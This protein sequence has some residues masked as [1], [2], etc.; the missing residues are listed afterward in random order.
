MIKYNQ[1]K[2]IMGALRISARFRPENKI[3]KD[4]AVSKDFTGVRGGKM[5][6]CAKCK[7][8]Y[9]PKQINIDH[10]KP[11]IPLNKKTE[12]MSWDEIIKRL[13]CPIFNLQVLCV[14]CHHEKSSK[15]KS[16]RT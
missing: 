12:D 16:E 2:Q 10:I 9:P 5:Y 7:N 4:L 1:S 6:I 11:V 3:V 15:E 8:V 13:F 14:D